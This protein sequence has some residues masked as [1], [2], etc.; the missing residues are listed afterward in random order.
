M[1]G[2]IFDQILW[3]RPGEG[4]GAAGRIGRDAE[5][6]QDHF[7]EFPVLPG[8]MAL[9]IFKRTAE[10]YLCGTGQ[11]AP[12]GIR[13]REIRQTRFSGY[14][15]PG[16]RWESR[17]ELVSREGAQTQWRG[18]LFCGGKAAVSSRMVLEDNLKAPVSG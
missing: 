5:Y 15:K 12:A 11:T 7:P 17:L 10:Q 14:L 18:Q 1:D 16:D 2:L 3:M 13:I 4:I 6:F 8:V 9:E